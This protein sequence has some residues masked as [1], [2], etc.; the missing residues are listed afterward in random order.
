MKM[1]RKINV[2]FIDAS[3]SD[4]ALK[5]H[6]VYRL[7]ESPIEKALLGQMIL[8]CPPDKIRAQVKIGPFR[9]D[10]LVGDHVIVECDGFDYHSDM[11]QRV[12]DGRRADALRLIGYTVLR[13]WGQQIDRQADHCAMQVQMALEQGCADPK[14]PPIQPGPEATEAIRNIFARWTRQEGKAAAPTVIYLP[15]RP[16]DA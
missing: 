12:R 5:A 7:C 9:V 15:S 14:M 8:A 16:L 2:G 6:P 3:D 4:E 1:H 10:F 13:F 11:E